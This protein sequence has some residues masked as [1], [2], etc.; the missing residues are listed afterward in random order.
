MVG[1]LMALMVM[2]VTPAVSGPTLATVP[3]VCAVNQ[4]QFDHG[5]VPRDLPTC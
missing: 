4:E 3:P 1:T 2:S 5:E